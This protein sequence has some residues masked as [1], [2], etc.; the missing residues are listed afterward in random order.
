MVH[1]MFRINWSIYDWQEARRGDFFYMM[2]TGDDKAGIVFSGQFITDPYPSDDWAGS[3]KRRM[4][5]DMICMNASED[6]IPLIS[7]EKLQESIPSIEWGKGHSGEI[8]S[9]EATDI[10]AKL[11]GEV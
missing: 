1:G 5:V 11:L 10:I 4:Y 8:L 3:N 9:D 6:S 2:R 7:I